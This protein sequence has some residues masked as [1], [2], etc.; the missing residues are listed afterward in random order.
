LG[1]IN[2]VI[3]K[4]RVSLASLCFYKSGGIALYYGEP[5]TEAEL[6]V[7]LKNR[8]RYSK[9]IFIFG[10][11]S[12]ILFSDD[13]ID[14]LFV[15]L[16]Y[17]NKWIFYKD[18]YF[19]A[20]AGV[21]LDDFIKYTLNFGFSKIAYLSGI[22]GTIGGAVSMNAGAFGVEMKDF[23]YEVSIMTLDGDCGKINNCDIGF[24]YRQ[25]KN[26]SDKIV[27][28]AKFKICI[29]GDKMKGFKVRNA[30]LK[31]RSLKQPL[32]YPSCGSVFKRG[33]DY[34]AGELI[35]KC[36]LKGYEIGGCEVSR[37]HANFI[38]N[39]NGAK[40]S[41][42]YSLIMYIKKTVK[43]KFNIDFEEEVKLVGFSR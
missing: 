34:F 40:S 12:N 35:E 39:R 2:S 31:K 27:L 24:S 16:R 15:S 3:I 18:N 14:C 43:D 32:E 23:A 26:L 17:F 11:G 9:D 5:L 21:I 29:E 22:P 7:I 33:K 38:I 4:N 36:G 37:K 41:D 20:G 30:I 13:E 1:T 28:M 25:A 42:I 10:L 19:Y 8:G 6:S